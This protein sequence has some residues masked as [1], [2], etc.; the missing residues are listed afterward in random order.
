MEHPPSQTTHRRALGWGL[1]LLTTVA[2]LLHLRQLTTED[3]WFDEVFSILTTAGSLGDLW[4]LTIADQVH[5]PGFY[6][7]L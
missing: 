6:L 2:A 3:P 5:P 4:R 1:V 7:L